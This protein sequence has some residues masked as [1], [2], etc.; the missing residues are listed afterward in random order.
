[1][2]EEDIRP[3]DLS[4]IPRELL[5]MAEEFRVLVMTELGAELRNGLPC[6]P[7]SR[8]EIKA[9]INKQYEQDGRKVLQLLD[10][11]GSESAGI[12]EKLQITRGIAITA[13]SILRDKREG[14][15]K[16]LSISR[17]TR[18]KF[19]FHGVLVSTMCPNTHYGMPCGRG[20]SFEHLLACYN[21]RNEGK[22]G[23]DAIDF[24][25]KLARVTVA[26]GQ[27]S[28]APTYVIAR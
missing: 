26:S 13:L 20:D 27:G 28:P 3:V 7:L 11:V 16:L 2:P 10:S 19:H 24:L 4:W 21:L 8:D 6:I 25:V 1:M 5:N 15:V 22:Q 12:L 14:Q 9:T 18:F 17:R 23:S